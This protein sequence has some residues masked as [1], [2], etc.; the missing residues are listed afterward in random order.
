[1]ASDL[2]LP[3]RAASN[4]ETGAGQH[5]RE[6]T[7]IT[8]KE[9][10]GLSAAGGPG[11]ATQDEIKVREPVTAVARFR[12]VRAPLLR[13]KGGAG[14]LV[15]GCCGGPPPPP[16]ASGGAAG[17]GRSPRVPSADLDTPGRRPAL[18]RPAAHAPQKA[19][20]AAHGAAREAPQ[21]ICLH[22][23]GARPPAAFPFLPTTL[24]YRLLGVRGVG[25]RA[26]GC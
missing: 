14:A 11:T 22:R 12:G 20:A 18:P 8:R 5:W 4:Y 9:K 16:A 26:E 24:S 3:S 2:L 6:K 23:S 25:R 1:M 15:G 17:A 13:A 19:A 21:L 10:G 7:F